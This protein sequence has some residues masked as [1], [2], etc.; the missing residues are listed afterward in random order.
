V[1]DVKESELPTGRHTVEI[2]IADVEDN[3]SRKIFTV[4]VK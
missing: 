4:I 3:L 2:E 1:I